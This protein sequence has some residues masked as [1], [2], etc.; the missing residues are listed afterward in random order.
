[1]EWNTHLPPVAFEVGLQIKIDTAFHGLAAAVR[2]AQ[3][4]I[5]RWH[6]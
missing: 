1:M 6:Q 2:A 3:N 5:N 4:V